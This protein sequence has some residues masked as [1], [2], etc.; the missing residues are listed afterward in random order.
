[1]KVRNEDQTQLKPFELLLDQ[2]RLS[3]RIAELGEEI[4]RDYAEK[5]PVLISVLKGSVVFLAD[6]IRTIKLNLEID[7][8][9]AASYRK[10]ARPDDDL[11]FKNMLSI[12]IK[13]RHVLLVECVVDSG[14]TVSAILTELRKLEPASI[15][16]VTLIDKPGS[17]RYKL[18]IRY[19]GFSLG[20]EFI[21]GFG[22]DNTQLYRNLPFIGKMVEE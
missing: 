13:N 14:R 19:K 5:N 15:E 2:E 6:L 17:H 18:D 8:V 21:I 11:L 1:M 10:G 20:N 3:K 9:A 16:V 22:L 7:F 4:T 12:P